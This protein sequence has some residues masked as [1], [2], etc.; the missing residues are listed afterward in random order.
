VLVRFASFRATAFFELEKRARAVAWD[1]FLAPGRPVSF[2]VSSHSSRLYHQGAIE[3]RLLD[4]VSRAGGV[5]APRESNE[6]EGAGAQLFVVRVV[7]DEFVLSADASGAPLHQRGYRQ[8]L[9]KA[10]LRETL[11]AAMLSASGWD[12]ATPLIDPMCGSGTIPIEGLLLAR[13]IPPGL[14]NPELAARDYAF[15][16]WP[17]FDAALWDGLVDRAREE[18]MPNAAPVLARDRDAGAVRAA[19]ENAGRAGVLDG[20]DL[21]RAPLSALEPP[22]GHAGAGTLVTNPPYGRRLGEAGSLRDLYAA[23]GNVARARLSGWIL[24][25]LSG[26]RRLEHQVGLVLRTAFRARNG[27]VPV[28]FLVGRIDH[29]TVDSPVGQG[30]GT[31]LG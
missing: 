25:L 31:A 17:D 27:G 21:Q 7:R 4:A 9:A 13:R 18:V 12:P 29:P 28:H 10:P 14:A 6:S 2:R 5:G 3:E 16:H 22:A 26:D 11:A 30:P 20:L 8:A 24:G 23:L 15:R 19:S 1:R